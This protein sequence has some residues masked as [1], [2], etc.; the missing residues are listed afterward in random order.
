MKVDMVNAE[1]EIQTEKAKASEEE[2][3]VREEL[4]QTNEELAHKPFVR[5]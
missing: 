4:Q 5:G 3:R 2:L 1:L